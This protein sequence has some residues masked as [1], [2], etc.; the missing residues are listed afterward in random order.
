[1][2]QCPREI[3]VSHLHGIV[4]TP[5]RSSKRVGD[6]HETTTRGSIG[7][8]HQQML[9]FALSIIRRVKVWSHNGLPRRVI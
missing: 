5:Q 1:M 9:A 8:E 6:T 3:G 4:Q 2:E 7:F